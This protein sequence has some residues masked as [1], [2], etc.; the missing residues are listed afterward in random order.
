MS[1]YDDTHDIEAKGYAPEFLDSLMNYHWPGNIREFFNILEHFL[2]L[3]V[4]SRHYSLFISRRHYAFPALNR[5]LQLTICMIYHFTRKS[6]LQIITGQSCSG[7]PPYDIIQTPPTHE[8]ACFLGFSTG[9][10]RC[11]PFSY[12][13]SR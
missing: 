8:N 9:N 13:D 2:I 10:N 5:H 11:F 12:H 7:I 4:M 6:C 3:H 1:R